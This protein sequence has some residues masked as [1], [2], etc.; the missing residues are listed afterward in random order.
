MKDID[1]DRDESKERKAYRT[2]WK[3]E[4]DRNEEQ[5]I[6][7]FAVVASLAALAWCFSRIIV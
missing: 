7:V 3:E 4:E 6:C 5:M 1:K 2:F